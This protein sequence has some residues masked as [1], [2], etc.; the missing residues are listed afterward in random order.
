[1]KIKLTF[2]LFISF[3]SHFSF[4]QIKAE[5]FHI[6]TAITG[7]HFATNFSGTEVYTPHGQPD[8]ET[9]NPTA[10]SY[11]IMPNA[12]YQDALDQINQLLSFTIKDGY[13]ETGIV[14]KDTSIN[15]NKAYC[16]SLLETQKGTNYKNL[17]FYAFY[18][19]GNAV[20]LF[21]SGDLD[22]GKYIENIKKT[23]YSIKWLCCMNNCVD[24]FY[25]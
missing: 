17:V 14:R 22:N 25:Y 12:T 20:L 4:G 13:T 15:G 23:F 10:F 7:F 9:I 5:D 16:V 2:L 8:L 6:D 24:K 19:K 11:T 1:M 3:S 18:V 21:V